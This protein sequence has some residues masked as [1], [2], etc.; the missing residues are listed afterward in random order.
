MIAS[1]LAAALLSV[2]GQDR[3]VVILPGVADLPMLPGAV[4]AP[5][6]GGFPTTFEGDPVACVTVPVDAVDPMVWAYVREA[7]TRGW[8][9]AGGA[10]TA[11][12]REQAGADGKC[13]R[14]TGAGFW[15]F[16]QWPEPRPGIPGY[17]AFS[18]RSDVRC[19]TPSAA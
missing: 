3:A 12:W 15:D 4:P 7:K 2:A 1:V 9:D 5:D 11:I 19:Q 10:A 16:R 13:R 8:T 14:L 6:C 17:V 18:V